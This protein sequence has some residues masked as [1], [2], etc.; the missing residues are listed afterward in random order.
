HE[1]KRIS[2][3]T[4][5]RLRAIEAAGAEVGAAGDRAAAVTGRTWIRAC[6]IARTAGHAVVDRGVT[7]APRTRLV[8]AT[9][10]DTRDQVDRVD[11][12][13]GLDVRR[14]TDRT[15]EGVEH[16]GADATR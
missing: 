15:V 12:I 14:T 2:R 10:P 6:R 8:D 13:A 9:G 4:T 1:C 5:D 7:D 11:R 3:R 16:A